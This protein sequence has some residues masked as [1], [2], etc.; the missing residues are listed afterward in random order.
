MLLS[1]PAECF[2]LLQQFVFRFLNRRQ[3]ALEIVFGGVNYGDSIVRSGNLS[4]L[5]DA[6]R[7]DSLRGM[8]LTQN[9]YRTCKSVRVVRYQKELP[10]FE[11]F[12]HL[13]SS[14][15]DLS[16]GFTALGLIVSY[17]NDHWIG[18]LRP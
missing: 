11:L 9:G 8:D 10:K 14:F 3:P 7:S 4:G 1:R 6:L 12:E 16:D 17:K 2:S 13:A 15:Q 18:S 5:N